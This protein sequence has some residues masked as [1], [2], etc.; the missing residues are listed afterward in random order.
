MNAMCR[1]CLFVVFLIGCG[2]AWAVEKPGPKRTEYDRFI[3]LY[4]AKSF[5]LGQAGRGYPPISDADR[6]RLDKLLSKL[7]EDAAYEP[8]MGRR[9]YLQVP[10][11]DHAQTRLYDR[12]NAPDEVWDICDSV[13]RMFDRGCWISS[14][15]A[16]FRSAVS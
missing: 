6:E 9:L 10:E 1:S 16:T 5:P 13:V 4:T 8:P 7:P 12:A 15:I 14:R 3:Q 2:M 11:G